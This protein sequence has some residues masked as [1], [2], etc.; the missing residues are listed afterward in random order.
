MQFGEQGARRIII[1][2]PLHTDSA[3]RHSRKHFVN[4]QGGRCQMRQTHPRQPCHC[5]KRRIGNAIGKLPD[6]RI[7]IAAKRHDLQIGSAGFDLGGPA[8]RR[9]A[10]HSPLRQGG[11]T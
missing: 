9:C 3:L 6:S 11:K 4:R 1:A 2:P 7:N 5:Q 8:Q 10:N